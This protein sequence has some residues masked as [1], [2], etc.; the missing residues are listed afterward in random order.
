MIHIQQAWN[1]GE[2]VND[3]SL[4]GMDKGGGGN[5]TSAAGMEKSDVLH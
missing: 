5:Y 2:G 1:K 3:K 4:E